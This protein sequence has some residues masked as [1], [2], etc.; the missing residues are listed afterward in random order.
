MHHSRPLTN[1]QSKQHCY[2]ARFSFISNFER[3]SARASCLALVQLEFSL[4]IFLPWADP[5][6]LALGIM[7]L[8]I[9]LGEGIERHRKYLRGTS[10]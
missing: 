2:P 10:E 6:I 4:I 9:E 7:L 1:V 5:K 8:E 3:L